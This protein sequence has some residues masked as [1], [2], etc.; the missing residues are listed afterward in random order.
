MAKL[1]GELV[2]LWPEARITFLASIRQRGALR[3]GTAGAGHRGADGRVA[4]RPLVRSPSLPLL[5]RAPQSRRRTSSA[6][7]TSCGERSPRQAGS[8]TS[9]LSPSDDTCEPG[10]GPVV[11]ELELHGIEEP[12]A[13]SVSRS[14]RRSTPG[15]TTARPH[16]LDVRRPA[17][18]TAEL[19]GARRHRLFRRVLGR[20]WRAER[21]RRRGARRGVC[22]A[23][24]RHP[25]LQLRSSA[26]T[27]RRGC[28]SSRART[29]TSWA[30]FPTGGAATRRGFTSIRSASAR[31][32]SSS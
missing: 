20:A 7:S 11:R 25:E 21:G 14:P 32:S 19:P 31:G 1:V 2:D 15:Q 18:P 27:R 12:T 17:R 26:P 4:I 3:D 16:P 30:S 13:C 9:K 24:R 10:E 6:S 5:G 8:M 22:P 29:S 23:R 28:A